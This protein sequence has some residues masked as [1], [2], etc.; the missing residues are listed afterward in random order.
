MPDYSIGTVGNCLGLR[1]RGGLQKIDA[2]YFQH[3]LYVSHVNRCV[4][5]TVSSKLNLSIVRRTAKY[6]VNTMT[7][8]YAYCIWQH[9]H[10]PDSRR[11]GQQVG[12]VDVVL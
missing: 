7:C 2:K 8:Q 3:T 4:L 11:V 5:C 12:V 9:P 1:R 6:Q 10:L